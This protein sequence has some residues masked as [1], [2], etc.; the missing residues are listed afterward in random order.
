MHLSTAVAES[1]RPNAIY[2]LGQMVKAKVQGSA[3]VALGRFAVNMD[4]E[5]VEMCIG[6][7]GESEYD[8]T[9]AIRQKHIYSI[10]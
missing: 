3:K 7:R 6:D 9:A 10:D 5:F 4:V 8:V 1:C 2:N